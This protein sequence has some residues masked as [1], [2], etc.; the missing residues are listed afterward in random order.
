M[1]RQKSISRIDLLEAL[2]GKS[3]DHAVICTYSFE[4]SFFEGYCLD[5]LSSLTNNGNISVITDRSIYE[6]LL[7]G[8]ESRK[9]KIANLRY[10]L[11][12]ISVPGVFHP[13]LFLLV[14]KNRGRLII[15]SANFTRPGITSNAEI[16]GCYDYEVEK[17]ESLKSIFQSA[18][19]YLV[20][21]SERWPSK[22]LTSNLQT[23]LRDAAWIAPDEKQDSLGD[24]ALLDNLDASLWKQICAEVEA[25]VD[26]VYVV[27]RYF[28]SAPQI[29]DRLQADLSPKRIKIYTQNGVTNLTSDWLKHP[30]VKNGQTEILLCHYTDDEQHSQS[31]HAKGIIIEQGGQ[32]IFAFGSANFTSAALLRTPQ[33]GNVETLLL[34]RKPCNKALIPEQMFDPN[35]QAIRLKRDSDLQSSWEENVN[36]EASRPLLSLHE[37]ILDGEQLFISAT[38]PEAV[39]ELSAILTFQYGFRSILVVGSWNDQTYTIEIPKGIISR[40][41]KSSTL[42]QLSGLMSDGQKVDSNLILVT[43]LLDIQNDKPV[44]RERYIKEAQQS[45]VQFFSVLKDL[46]QGGDEKALLE[47]L[48]YCDIRAMCEPRPKLFQ[49]FKPVW[50]GGAGMRSLGEKNLRVH[51]QL[52]DATLDFFD[53]HYK[54]LQRHVR[55]REPESIANFLHIFLAMGGVLR[56]QMERLAQGLEA[57]RTPLEIQEWYESRSH[58]NIYF[59]CFKLMTDC[60]WNEY[61]IPLLKIYKASEIREQFQPDLQPLDDLY[62]DMLDFQQRIERLRATT[63]L[64]LD[65][66]GQ[67]QPPKY[68][69]CVF[70]PK[71]WLRYEHDLTTLL[72]SIERAVA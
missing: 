9:P 58:I 4:S 56:A 59:N 39:K 16:A 43:N 38:V 55:N 31:L 51:M 63:L 3:Y 27:S 54:R 46:L 20:K 29:L 26:T 57:K 49:G 52:H 18:F 2:N 17:D 33:R 68:W 65:S 60:L 61:L 24:F 72:S 28:D 48:N 13:K 19:E 5:R 71:F 14:S 6:G 70:D 47:F 53:R 40:L 25:P 15:G 1:A 8:A 35:K 23:I 10:L 37:A 7:A 66:R 32:R 42:I 12:P 36:F 62:W 22:Q 69:D 41:D 34:L 67:K 45:A 50:D 21:L 64:M 11:H 44:R 30:S